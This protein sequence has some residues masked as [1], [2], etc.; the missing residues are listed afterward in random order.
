MTDFSNIYFYT[1]EGQSS[2]YRPAADEG[3]A[4]SN[5]RNYIHVLQNLAFLIENEIDLPK[6]ESA[7]PFNVMAM[8]LNYESDEEEGLF[9]GARLFNDGDQVVLSLLDPLKGDEYTYANKSDLTQAQF[10]LAAFLHELFAGSFDL[11]DKSVIQADDG[12][13]ELNCNSFCIDFYDWR[14]LVIMIGRFAAS[15]GYSVD[16]FNTK[17]PKGDLP[18][19]LQDSFDYFNQVAIDHDLMAIAVPHLDPHELARD[20]DQPNPSAFN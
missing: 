19:S 16:M 17:G 5:A 13:D 9:Y 20:G 4:E 12:K 10:K 1:E 2:I 3:L 8:E 6:S 14:G 11:Y 7:H 18:F 15:R